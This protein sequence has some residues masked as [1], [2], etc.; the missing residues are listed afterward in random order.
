MIVTPQKPTPD[1]M[2]NRVAAY[3]QL[4]PW[5]FRKPPTSKHSRGREPKPLLLEGMGDRL[6]MRDMLPKREHS[7]RGQRKRA[8]QRLADLTKAM[9]N[10]FA[11]AMLQWAQGRRKEKPDE[12]EMRRK[13]HNSRPYKKALEVVRGGDA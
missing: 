8:L 4:F 11:D 10:A 7:E 2:Y 3:A 6:G 5:A 1:Q 9:E 13:L 12:D